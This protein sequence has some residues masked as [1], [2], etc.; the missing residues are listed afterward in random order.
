MLVFEFSPD[1]LDCQYPKTERAEYSYD[2]GEEGSISK[3]DYREPIDWVATNV[4]KG[5]YFCL[6]LS[7][8][9]SGEVGALLGRLIWYLSALNGE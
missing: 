4:E 9:F 7:F 2:F 1:S 3:Q 5:G 8:S 6:L